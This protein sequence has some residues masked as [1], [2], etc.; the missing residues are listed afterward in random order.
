MHR[1]DELRAQKILQ[2]RAFENEKID[3]YW[4]TEM[5][6]IKG[7]GQVK[8]AV[9]VNNQTGEEREEEIDGVFIYIGLLPLS[10][11]FKGLGILNDEN[12]VVTNENMETSI[13]GIFAAGDVREKELRQIVT[14]TSDGSIAGQR[15]QSYIEDLMERS[16][17]QRN[18]KVKGF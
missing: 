10:D 1:R 6:E 18:K 5:K 16:V 4:N 3:F 14:A 12:Q 2:D 7:D 15:A 17:Q 11:P 13:P 8:T 9:L